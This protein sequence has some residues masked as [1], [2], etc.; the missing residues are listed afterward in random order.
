M[1]SHPQITV[2]IDLGDRKSVVCVLDVDAHVTERN[3]VNGAITYAY[4]AAG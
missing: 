1:H 4:T 3:L 2:G